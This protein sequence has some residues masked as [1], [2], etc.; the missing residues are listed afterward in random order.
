MLLLLT[1]GCGNGSSETRNQETASLEQQVQT[2]QERLN[3]LEKQHQEDIQ[4]LQ[5]DLKNV[6][7]YLH[8]TLKSMSGE[9][10]AEQ[11]GLGEQARESLRE[12]MQKLLDLSKEMIEK[13]ERELE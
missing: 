12:N 1:A 3:G 7:E 13:L 8:I 2:L 5:K 9:K 4:A 6:L 11:P 10:P